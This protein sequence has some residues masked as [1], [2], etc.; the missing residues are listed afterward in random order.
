MCF[1]TNKKSTF[2]H[3]VTA[4][5]LHREPTAESGDSLFATTAETLPP[6]EF[7]IFCSLTTSITPQTLTQPKDNVEQLFRKCYSNIIDTCI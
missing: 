3:K 5:S 4:C 2:S 6:A 1:N 7:I